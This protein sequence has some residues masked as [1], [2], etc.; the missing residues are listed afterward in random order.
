MGQSFYLRSQPR[1]T[2]DKFAYSSKNGNKPTFKYDKNQVDANLS[3][4]T[5]ETIQSYLHFVTKL[6][7]STYPKILT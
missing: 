5:K 1:K 3:Q 7:N 4:S 6:R 2:K